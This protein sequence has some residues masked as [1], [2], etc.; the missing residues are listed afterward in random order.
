M[1]FLQNG[2]AGYAIANAKASLRPCMFAPKSRHAGNARKAGLRERGQEPHDPFRQL[3]ESAKRNLPNDR[4][5]FHGR[6][7]E[8]K[9]LPWLH[10]A[11]LA[12]ERPIAC[13][14]SHDCTLYVRKHGRLLLQRMLEFR[15][16]AA[17]AHD[18]AEQPDRPCA[19]FQRWLVLGERGEHHVALD[20]RHK[21]PAIP[22]QRPQLFYPCIECHNA[23]AELARIARPC[24]TRARFRRLRI[25]W[26]KLDRLD[27]RH[28]LLLRIAQ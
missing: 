9:R 26:P 25:R 17:L 12:Q 10:H 8:P 2:R 16:T 6:R 15:K 22:E 5:R 11:R 14:Q 20:R 23:D 19:V 7:Q 27:F 21:G 4:A 13:K 3:V 28:R 18:R 1:H 24:I